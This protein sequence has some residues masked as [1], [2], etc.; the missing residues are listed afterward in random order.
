MKKWSLPLL[1]FL[2]LASLATAASYTWN[3]TGS[4]AWNVA[5]NWT[6]SRD[7]PA[8]DDVLTIDG[9]V[10]A[11]P[12]ITSVPTKT[13]GELHIV[14]NAYATLSSAASI[15]LTIAGG[16]S[17]K[18]LEVAAGST[19]KLTGSQI[20]TISIGATANGVVEGDVIFNATAASIPHRILANQV[21]GLVF[22]SGATCAMAPTTTGA[23]GGF[24][25][26]SAPTSVDNGVRFKDGSTYY[27]GGLKDG[28]FNGG[29][30]ANPFQKT[31]PA[32]C[33]VFDTNATYVN[34]SGIPASSS[35]SYGNF[36]W[37]ERVAER[38]F[39]GTNCVVK[40]D[41]IL[42]PPPAGGTV[43][44]Y[45]YT[46]TGDPTITIEGDFIIKTGSGGFFD[47]ADLT[48]ASRFIIKGDL[49][50]E[51]PALFN[52]S[53]NA[54]RVYVING[55]AAQEIDFAG[56]TAPALTIDNAAGV[57]LADNVTVSGA[58]DLAAGEVATSPTKVLTANGAVT[59]ATGFVTGVLARALDSAALGVTQFPVG[60]AGAYSP[61]SV[62][63]TAAGTGAGPVQVAAIAA[64]QPN[65]PDASKAIDR[66]WSL[67]PTGISGYTATLVFAYQDTDVTGAAV[68]A[69]LKAA[70]YNGAWTN[71]M[72]T[73]IDTGA[74][75]ATVAGVTSLS[76]WTLLVPESPVQDWTLY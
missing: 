47:T 6:P 75:T 19:L 16:A 67:T 24:G 11:T 25:G 41:L 61:V 55:A 46:G 45:N 10:T 21:D 36:I 28:T 31:A 44:K 62:E 49:V 73:V 50:V 23:G 4:A 26:S 29:T 71:Y 48:T 57:L 68:E 20:V 66:Y 58:L 59:R 2:A 42:E 70:A 12:D 72:G 35:R 18:D 17:A 38:N 14:N 54:N 56:K 1:A 64:D 13:I 51:N 15:T 63:I 52:P 53:S 30:G 3:Q 34:I 22:E 60:T 76:D 5:A 33:V 39:G 69:D 32:S 27:Q 7:T 74:N 40:G 65:V 37:R 9:A 8:T 43:S